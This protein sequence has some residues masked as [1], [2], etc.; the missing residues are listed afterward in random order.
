MINEYEW[1]IRITLGR[2]RWRV[3]KSVFQTTYLR[4]QYAWLDHGRNV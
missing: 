2:H 4:F 3:F 1:I